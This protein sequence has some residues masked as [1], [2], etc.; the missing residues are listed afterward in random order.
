MLAR[1]AKHPL[2]M[3][4]VDQQDKIHPDEK[5]ISGICVGG[6]QVQF[7]LTNKNVTYGNV[8]DPAHLY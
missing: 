8:Q 2:K 1:M 5:L 3:Y 6:G 7:F 4:L